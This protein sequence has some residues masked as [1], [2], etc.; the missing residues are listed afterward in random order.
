MKPPA[1][2]VLGSISNWDFLDAIFR[3]GFES[4]VRETMQGA[5]A[6]LRREG[7]AAIV[8]DRDHADV[9]VLEFVLNVRDMDQETPVI[10]VGSSPDDESHQALMSQPR[11]LLLGKL[12]NP[13]E[14]LEELKK[15]AIG[16]QP[17]DR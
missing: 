13:D 4:L 9:D 17:Y 3:A 16:D 11:T 12:E 2:L 1:V 10:V 8:V 14:L 15:L 7:F 5:I 6:K